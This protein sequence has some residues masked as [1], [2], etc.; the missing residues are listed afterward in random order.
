VWKNKN[1]CICKAYFLSFP[2]L[3]MYFN[4][5]TEGLATTPEPTYLGLALFLNSSIL[6]L[7]WFPNPSH[8]GLATFRDPSVKPSRQTQLPF[9]PFIFFDYLSL[10][11]SSNYVRPK[12]LGLT[13]HVRPKHVGSSSHD[14]PNY[15]GFRCHVKPKVLG[16]CVAARPKVFGSSTHT[17][18]SY[19]ENTLILME[20][21]QMYQSHLCTNLDK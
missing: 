14:W 7:T 20:S 3:K 21:K 16:S 13:G 9:H 12:Q 5:L 18:L 10:V 11:E 8:L 15:L 1:T 2:R 6:G 17:W 19:L 4:Y